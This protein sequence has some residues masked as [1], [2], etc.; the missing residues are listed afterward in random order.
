MMRTRRIGIWLPWLFALTMF[1]LGTCAW[2]QEGGNS[3]APNQS[4][5]TQ[6]SDG[7]VNWKGVGL[8]AGAVAGN[9]LYV[10]AKLAYG[11]LGGIGGAAG[12][13]LTGGNKDVANSIWRSSLGGDYVLTPDMMAGKEPIYFSGPSNS[14][15]TAGSQINSSP[16]SESTPNTPSASLSKPAIASSDPASASAAAG[17]ENPPI[18]HPVDNG[19]GLVSTDQTRTIPYA[20]ANNPDSTYSGGSHPA[21]TKRSRLSDS[22]IE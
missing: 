13:A 1:Y 11:I 5:V 4:Q 7:G 18:T 12:Y 15:T 17:P 9:I 22:S 10:P 2:A 3:T 6:P 8:G 20:G 21:S 16:S 14:G 19:A